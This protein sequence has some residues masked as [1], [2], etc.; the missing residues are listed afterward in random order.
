MPSAWSNVRIEAGI[1]R[2]K[3]PTFIIAPDTPPTRRLPR[4]LEPGDCRVYDARGR[5]VQIIA[6]VEGKRERFLPPKEK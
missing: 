1:I 5:L 2:K 3:P 6:V 4:A